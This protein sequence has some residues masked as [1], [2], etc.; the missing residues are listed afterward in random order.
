MADKSWDE[1][2]QY[3]ADQ[4]DLDIKKDKETQK[5]KKILEAAIH[6]FAEKGFSGA[7]HK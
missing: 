7:S 6:V 1:W 4:Y 2:V 3:I 5:Q